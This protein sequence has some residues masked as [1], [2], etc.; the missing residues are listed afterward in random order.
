LISIKDG[1]NSLVQ[2]TRMSQAGRTQ[3][4]QNDAERLLESARKSF[5][6][7]S[8]APTGN[9]IERYAAMGRDYLELAHQAAKVDA[10]LPIPSIW[11]LP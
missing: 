6:L 9:D 4:P 8:K 3:D 7:A 1:H 2:G 11:N 10:R 5:M